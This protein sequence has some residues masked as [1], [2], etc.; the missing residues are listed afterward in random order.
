MA[1]VQEIIA[2]YKK[3][4]TILNSGGREK[5]IEAYKVLS[6]KG[7]TAEIE[8]QRNLAIQTLTQIGR[9]WYTT[10]G[11]QAYVKQAQFQNNLIKT[12]FGGVRT[13]FAVQAKG[14]YYLIAVDVSIDVNGG[15]VVTQW[16]TRESVSM[17]NIPKLLSGNIATLR[18]S[19]LSRDYFEKYSE[20]NAITNAVRR[21]PEAMLKAV[22]ARMT[23]KI[24]QLRAVR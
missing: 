3:A 24:Q 7:A 6:A 17:Q 14:S 9:A 5:Q 15:V 4:V 12:S 16:L 21:T 2:N 10:A 11:V 1:S 19:E 23:E 13:M 22:I 20:I 8:R 18:E